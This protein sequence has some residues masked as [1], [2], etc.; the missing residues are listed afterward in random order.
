MAYKKWII[1]DADKEKAS[2]L[3]EQLN[4]DPFIA[5]MLIARGIESSADAAD[6]LASSYDFSDPFQ[7]WEMERAVSAV[8]EAV[9]YGEKITV[10]GD[11]DCDGVTS[12]V[13]LY[14]FVRDMGADVDYYI[15]SRLDAG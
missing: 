7:L 8:E 14:T 5:L 4:I 10:F 1:A 3:S 2:D 9:E 11:Y 15:P 6:F 12:T 13:L